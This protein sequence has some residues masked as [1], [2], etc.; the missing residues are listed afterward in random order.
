MNETTK[1]IALDSIRPHPLD[2][3]KP[4]AA[5]KLQELADSIAAVGLLDPVIVREK[6]RGYEFL[7]GKN[8]AAAARLNGAAEIDAKVVEADDDEALL[9]LTE[10]N[11]KHR[12]KLYPSERGAAYSLQLEALKNQG[13]RTDLEENGTSCPVDTKLDSA[14][15]VAEHNQISRREVYRYIRLTRLIPV[16]LNLADVERLPIRVGVN[17]SFLDEE[18]QRN[19]YAFYYT[20][21]GTPIDVEMSGYFKRVYER[22]KEP[23]T[24]KWLNELANK[25]LPRKVN[26]DPPFKLD[27]KDIAEFIHQEV[28][29]NRTLL[30]LFVEFLTERYEAHGSLEASCKP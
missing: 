9:I 12:D 26:P 18:S 21:R 25:R 8:R 10:S 19:V 23:I 30:N 17:L 24:M 29:D 22:R 6:D 11:L 5:D 7:A 20:E 2:P 14:L 3:F 27:R 1:R 28:P 15:K 13:K 16:L 4:Y